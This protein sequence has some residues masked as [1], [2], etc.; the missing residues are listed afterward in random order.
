MG[1]KRSN[2]AYV[3]GTKRLYGENGLWDSFDRVL[4]ARSRVR[5]TKCNPLANYKVLQK[6]I[7]PIGYK[8]KCFKLARLILKILGDMLFVTLQKSIF[9]K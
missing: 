3:Q 5:A 2:G 1:H 8:K 9:F 7:S 6:S 4:V